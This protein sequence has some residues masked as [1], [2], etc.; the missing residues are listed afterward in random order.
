MPYQKR[1]IRNCLISKFGFEE[2][3]GSR[4]EAVAFFYEGKKVATTRFSRKRKGNDIDNDLLGEMAKQIHVYTLNF[5][6]GMV[7]CTQSRDAFI[8]RLKEGG[9]I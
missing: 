1:I 8:K 3:E 6:K 7:D 9:F 5:F 2:V 4:H